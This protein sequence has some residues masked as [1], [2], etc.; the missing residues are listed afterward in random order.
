MSENV[1]ALSPLD[2]IMVPCWVKLLFY[3]ST[4]PEASV[5][6][7]YQLLSKGFSL[8]IAEMPICGGTVHLRPQDRPGWKPNQLEVRIPKDAGKNG[9]PTLDFKD[10]TVA[11]GA[12]ELSYD[13]LR[14]AG[15]PA[16]KIDTK[17][18]MSKSFNLDLAS[19]IEATAAQANFVKGGCLLGLAMWH[20][21][22]DAYGVYTFARRWA[23]HCRRLQS[24]PGSESA[25][26]SYI[27][28]STVATNNDREVLERLWREDG[29]S[30]AST[31]TDRRWSILGIHPPSAVDAPRLNDVLA[32]LMG[33]PELLKHKTRTQIFTI[34][35]EAL[36]NLSKVVADELPGQEPVT[37]DDALHA[38]L[39][40][41]I[42][43][44]R[45]PHAVSP[46]D[47]PS[48]SVYQIA[49]DGREI[50]GGPQQQLRSY[51]G[52]TFFFNTSSLPLSEVTDLPSSSSAPLGKLARTLRETHNSLSR[53]D[54]LA[55][56]SAAHNLSSYE[57]LPYSLAGVSGPSMIVVSHKYIALHDLDFGPALGR[58][59]CERPPGDEWNDLFRRTI[60]LPTAS[61]KGAEILVALH[62][63]EMKR[64][65]ADGEFRSYAKLSTC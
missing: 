11:E 24:E 63:D 26:L 22:V 13:R 27:P 39:W 9:S 62:D 57:N 14:A 52:D 23:S 33:N 35:A 44:A 32:S 6:E 46:G 41:C 47:E 17:L 56:F 64:L 28:D 59:D 2:N 58:P 53:A 21:V 4:P 37:T 19:G 36:E 10:L 42:M 48:Q 30:E 65:E 29:G 7:T 16:D 20:N 50:L 38:L 61:G 60:I 45:Y 8:A 1:V 18:L 25:S 15:F 43:R 34:S 40:R 55:A 5:D 51:L 3:F 12:S 49:V 31:A 54:L